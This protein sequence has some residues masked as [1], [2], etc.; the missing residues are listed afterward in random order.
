M[1]GQSQTPAARILHCEREGRWIGGCRFEARYDKTPA[2]FPDRLRKL[3]GDPGDFA[4][5][6]EGF[7]RV[8]YVRDVCVRC[9]R[10]IERSP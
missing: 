4:E 3:G 1:S 5:A 2:E 9:G 6:L 8:T 10:T 7:R